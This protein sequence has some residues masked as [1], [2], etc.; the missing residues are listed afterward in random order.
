MSERKEER[1]SKEREMER[2]EVIFLVGD[3]K[4]RAMKRRTWMYVCKSLWK[5][6]SSTRERKRKKETNKREFH[7]HWNKSHFFS[8]FASFFLFFF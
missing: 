4:K 7:K 1:E 2:E 3:K 6:A 8:Y 5:N